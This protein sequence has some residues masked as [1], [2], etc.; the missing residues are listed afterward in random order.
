MQVAVELLPGVGEDALACVGFI[1][2]VFGTIG[3]CLALEDG[4]LGSFRN[5]K[6]GTAVVARR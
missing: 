3:M 1:A 4:T 6:C 2:R 5:R